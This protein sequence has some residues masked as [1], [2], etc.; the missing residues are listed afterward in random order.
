MIHIRRFASD[1]EIAR[2]P[3]YTGFDEEEG[4]LFFKKPLSKYSA[5]YLFS[6]KKEKY[7]VFRAKG[8]RFTG[9]YRGEPNGQVSLCLLDIEGFPLYQIM[10]GEQPIRIGDGKST[11]ASGKIQQ[12]GIF[13]YPAKDILIQY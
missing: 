5:R 11:L 3:D 1:L 6:H 13:Y 10:A 2:N 12:F 7:V 9:T 4:V 8:S